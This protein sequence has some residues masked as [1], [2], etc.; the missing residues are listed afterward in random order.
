M[1]VLGI[2]P[3]RYESSRFPGKPLIDI[4]GKTMIERVY[5]RAKKSKKID[6]LVVATD[7][8]R[9]FEEVKRFGGTVVMTEKHHKNGTE[10]CLEVAQ[11]LH[12]QFILNIQGDEPF[13]HPDQIDELCS[14]I[15]SDTDLATLIRRIKDPNDLDN[16]NVVKVVKSLDDHA[17]YFSRSSIPFNRSV[18][19][20]S[21]LHLSNAYWKHIGIYAYRTEVLQQI[22]KLKESELEKIESLEQLRWIENGF[23]IKTAETNFEANG[24]DTPEDLNHLIAKMKTG[25]LKE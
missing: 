5:E 11:S 1:K 17:I 9:I 25:T 13:I 19:G 7:D 22:V 20:I 23:K 3:S 8:K 10:R 2:I 21:A 24:I 12:S 6:E 16:P 4:M 18:K 15:S 14:V